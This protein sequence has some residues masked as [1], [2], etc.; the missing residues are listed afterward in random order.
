MSNNNNESSL[1]ESLLTSNE[2][3][4]KK[5]LIL[6]ISSLNDLNISEKLLS[7]SNN[8]PIIKF[9]QENLINT[10]LDNETI[11]ILEHNSHN[12]IQ[13]IE[14]ELSNYPTSSDSSSS[15]N[16]SSSSSSNSSSGNIK[17][18]QYQAQA[19]PQF[20][21]LTPSINQLAQNQ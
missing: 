18:R 9:S 17:L 20:H 12:D 15:S 6:I 21:L 16:S 4:Y 8:L 14:D 1:Q 19:H 2:N 7:N 3:E 13:F 11:S 5:I 10:N